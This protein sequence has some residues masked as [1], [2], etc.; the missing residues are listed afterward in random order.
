MLVLVPDALGKT[1][2]SQSKALIGKLVR[3]RK[4]LRTTVWSTYFGQSTSV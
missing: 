4:P 2:L 3:E 1:V